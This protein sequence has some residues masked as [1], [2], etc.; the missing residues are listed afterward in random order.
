MSCASRHKLISASRVWWSCALWT[1]LLA[2]AFAQDDDDFPYLLF[3][4]VVIKVIEAVAPTADVPY[5]VQE[6]STLPQAAPAVNLQDWLAQRAVVPTLPPEQ[7]AADIAAYE[8]S[9]LA[10]ESKGGV[11]DPGLDEELL[12]LGSL[13]LQAGDATRAQ[14]VLERA[15]H[16]NRV[17]DGLFTAGQLPIIDRTIDAHLARGDL[18]AADT[19][20]EYLLYVQQKHFDSRGA[21]LLPALTR[22]AEWNLYAFRAR[23][24]AVA[25]AAGAEGE[26]AP[27]PETDGDAMR[28]FRTSRL[29]TAHQAYQSLITLV[30]NN[31]GLGDSRLLNFERQLALTNYLYISTFGAEGELDP[32]MLSYGGMANFDTGMTARPPL[33]FR[34]GRDSLERRIT[35][36]S[37]K[38]GVTALERAQAMLDLADWTLP[39]QRMGSL[40]LYEDIWHELAAAGTP[41]AEL[42]A[43][44]D[45]AFPIEIPVY[46]EHPYTRQALGIPQ[47]Q[48]LKYKGYIDVEFRLS[49]A[50]ETSSVRIMNKSLTTPPRLESLLVRHLRYSRFRPRIVHGNLRDNETMHVR[51]YFTY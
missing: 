38:P 51:F 18:M 8:Q 2:P 41:A 37:D 9:V 45:P 20:Q 48:A 50:G 31:F 17:N 4:P 16:V 24:R 30:A 22:Y 28:E 36:L 34:Q 49:R 40:E 14:Q 3:E 10:L 27:P 47:D 42:D 39:Y 19:Q 25:P 29:I 7:L 21:D 43:L 23:L 32:M 6:L 35:Y 33:G 11:F 12:A 26:T 15:L 46:V 1:C 44:F 5:T 13:L